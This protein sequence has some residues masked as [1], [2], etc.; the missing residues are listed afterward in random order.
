MVFFYCSDVHTKAGVTRRFNDPPSWHTITKL[1]PQ[2]RT[3]LLINIHKEGVFRTFTRSH[4]LQWLFVWSLQQ[5]TQYLLL[6]PHST[7]AI[8]IPALRLL[9]VESYTQ[10]VGGVVLLHL[11]LCG[12]NCSPVPPPL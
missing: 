8:S 3:F 12:S 5:F 1:L 10:N 11:Y 7:T 4:Q 6:V 9:C 2:P